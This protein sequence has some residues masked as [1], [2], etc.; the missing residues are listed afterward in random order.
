MPEI[1]ERREAVAKSL[2]ARDYVNGPPLWDEATIERRWMERL[3]EEQQHYL[4]MAD[5]ALLALAEIGA[6]R[7]Y[8]VSA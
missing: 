8:A 7:E 1:E 3:P 4:W 2:C 5:G 6:L